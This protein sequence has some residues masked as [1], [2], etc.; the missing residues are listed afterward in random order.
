MA[1]EQTQAC[2]TSQGVRKIKVMTRAPGLGASATQ[3][4]KELLWI[5]NEIMQ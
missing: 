5:G 2:L 3:G 1:S 4:P